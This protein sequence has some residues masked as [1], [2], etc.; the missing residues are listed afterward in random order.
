MPGLFQRPGSA[1]EA[2]AY[3]HVVRTGSWRFVTPRLPI[4]S[5]LSRETILPICSEKSWC[6]RH[7]FGSAVRLWSS[8]SF[9]RQVTQ[10]RVR[11]DCGE[12][13]ELQAEQGCE[14][15]LPGRVTSVLRL[16]RGVIQD[17]TFYLAL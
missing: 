13:R 1:I 16:A 3:R 7:F 9:L 10:R 4:F 14:G 17:E 5:G 8:L 11:M 2:S 15:A 6:L 12:A